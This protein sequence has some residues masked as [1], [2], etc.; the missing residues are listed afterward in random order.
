MQ[1]LN[2]NGVRLP[3]VSPHI[4]RLILM[5]VR[6]FR[7]LDILCGAALEV[8]QCRVPKGIDIINHSQ[9]NNRWRLSPNSL[10]DICIE[11][12][13]IEYHGVYYC[14]DLTK[15]VSRRSSGGEHFIAL[16][17]LVLLQD[18]SVPEDLSRWSEYVV[19]VGSELFFRNEWITE[20]QT[21]AASIF[22]RC[23]VW[24][25]AIFCI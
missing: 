2:P 16:G 14:Y 7:F 22:N 1:L 12:R 6:S 19:A 10:T 5:Q 13:N 3:Y 9:R 18:E 20:L 25:S 4:N 17:R 21:P 24:H 11:Q 15:G 8:N 23:T